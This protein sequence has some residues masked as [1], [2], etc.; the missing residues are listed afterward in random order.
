[1]NVVFQRARRERGIELHWIQLAI[2]FSEERVLPP[3]LPCTTPTQAETLRAGPDKKFCVS[4][5]SFIYKSFFSSV[6]LFFDVLLLYTFWSLGTVR[7]SGPDAF[8]L[9][10]RSI[11]GHYKTGWFQQTRYLT[12][13]ISCLWF[14]AS[15]IDGWTR[16][17]DSLFSHRT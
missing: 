2:K 4:C 10:I 11:M 13:D 14:G 6:P 15:N 5:G 1:M 7:I 9:S 8:I 3:L 17:Q 12:R 16:H